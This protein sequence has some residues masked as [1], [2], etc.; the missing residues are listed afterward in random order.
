MSKY[1]FGRFDFLKFSIPFAVVSVVLTFMALGDI[2][3]QG[4]NYGVDFAGGTEIQVQ[5]GAPVKASQ[6]REFT[7]QVGFPDA[8]VQSI[9]DDNEF[10]IRIGTVAGKTESETNTILN[11]TIKKI[12][13]GLT[14]HFSAES[15][16][17][18]RVDTVGP[19]VGSELKKNGILAAFYALLLILIYIGLRFDYEFAPGAVF[20]LFHDAIITMGIYSIFDL[21]VT[22]QTMAAILTI[23]GYSLNDTIIIFDRMRENAEVYRGKDFRWLANRSMND[24][25]SRTL[26]TSITTFLTVTAMYFLAGGVIADFALT[27]MIGIIL[28]TYSTMYVAIPLVLFFDKMQKSFK[29]A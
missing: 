2:F 24:T 7:T 25:L 11:E 8:S 4:F 23:I 10:L 1:D 3:L 18:R 26:L 14:Q 15:P 13:D 27:M 16:N 29:K 5:F 6:V 9:G 20:C 19:Q 12:T 22:V 28:G 21:E 17:V